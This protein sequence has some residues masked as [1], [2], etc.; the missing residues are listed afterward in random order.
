MRLDGS[1][2]DRAAVP[3]SFLVLAGWLLAAPMAWAGGVSLGVNRMLVVSAGDSPAA[4]CQGLKDVLASITDATPDNPY[5][6][7]LEPGVFACGS[8][9]ITMKPWVDI[10]GSGQELTR[11]TSFFAGSPAFATVRGKSNAEIRQLTLEA[12]GGGAFDISIAFWAEA[13]DPA[14]AHVT[15]RAYGGPENL[16]LFAVSGASPSLRDVAIEVTD[17]LAS[18]NTGLRLADA[19]AQLYAVYVTVAGGTNGFGLRLTGADTVGPVTRLVVR[20]SSI[21][22][23]ADINAYGIVQSLQSEAPLV[24]GSK[25]RVYGALD[26]NFAVHNQSSSITIR[27]STLEASGAPLADYFG[28]YNEL[29][30]AGT[31]LVTVDNSEIIGQTAP[32][33]NDFDFTTKIRGSLMSGGVIFSVAPAPICAGVWDENYVF[34]AGPTCN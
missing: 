18:K 5:L 15:L 28:I 32:V 14:L 3:A 11:I 17:E 25:I 26:D 31:F 2:L 10:E 6:L 7:K 13:E 22:V 12:D 8:Q 23:T 9:G 33:R 34:S 29:T 20:D 4:N 19:A 1:D 21:Y 27:H 16:G 24:M 30:T